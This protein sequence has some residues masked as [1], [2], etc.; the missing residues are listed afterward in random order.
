MR[1]DDESEIQTCLDVDIIV[2][3]QAAWEG[4]WT[5]KATWTVTVVA[6]ARH[7]TES[8]L[9]AGSALCCEI[10]VDGKLLHH[11]IYLSKRETFTNHFK[12]K[13]YYVPSII[14]TFWRLAHLSSTCARLELAGMALVC[15]F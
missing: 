7:S 10:N 6:N 3:A 11:E 13:K 1:H 12:Q 9:A 5:P 4:E 2:A 14:T 15:K 8:L